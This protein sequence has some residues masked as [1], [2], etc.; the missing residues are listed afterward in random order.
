MF[1]LSAIKVK[2]IKPEIYPEEEKREKDPEA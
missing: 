2:K 1:T